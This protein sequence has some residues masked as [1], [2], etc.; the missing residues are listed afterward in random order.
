[1][2]ESPKPK[3]SWFQTLPGVLTAVAAAVTAIAGLIGGLH[4]AGL[5]GGGDGK[6]T[7]APTVQ[8]TPAAAVQP[9]PA[10]TVQSTPAPAVRSCSGRA[11]YPL[12]RWRVNDKSSASAAS[13]TFV[14]F[15]RPTGGTWL[16]YSGQGSFES[17]PAPSPG[18]EVVLKLRVDS[19]NYLS[20]NSLVVSPDGCQMDGTYNDSEG[21]RGEA[22]YVYD[23]PTG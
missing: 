1:M 12:G 15:T 6:P 8:S 16:P 2:D 5:F 14:T 4:Q 10:S 23:A 17:F 19:G 18:V 22:T 11:G 9:T 13:S 3:S 21:H 7:P 20:T